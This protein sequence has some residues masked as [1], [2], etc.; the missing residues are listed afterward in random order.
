[1]STTSSATSSDKG[2]S[3]LLRILKKRMPCSVKSAFTSGLW[4]IWLKKNALAR[5]FLD[6][7]VRN[8]NRILHAKTKPEVPGHHKPN[9]P[10]IQDR[11]G[12]I[13]L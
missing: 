6:G 3:V 11:R 9:A 7:T 5:V 2:V 10:E 8:L 12:E 13:S 4:I 1:M